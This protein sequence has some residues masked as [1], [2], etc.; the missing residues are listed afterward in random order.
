MTT[1]EKQ[2]LLGLW[3]VKGEMRI[4][5]KWGKKH[6]VLFSDL[7]NRT[8]EKHNLIGGNCLMLSHKDSFH[9]STD[10]RHLEIW[11]P[12]PFTDYLTQKFPWKNVEILWA[13]YPNQC[14]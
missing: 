4:T 6:D 5:D 7:K 10:L 8:I 11:I 1:K 14:H 2:K 9:L 12:G 13:H 3:Q